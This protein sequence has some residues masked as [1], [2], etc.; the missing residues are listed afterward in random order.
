[1]L[2][3]QSS[4]HLAEINSKQMKVKVLTGK[5]F[6]VS[7]MLIAGISQVLAQV[8]GKVSDERDNPIPFANVVL[9]QAVDTTLVTGAITDDAGYFSLEPTGV[10]PFRVRVTYLG[11]AD[12][13]SEPF[14]L[15][16]GSPSLQLGTLVLTENVNELDEVVLAARRDWVQRTPE[17]QVINVQSSVMTKGS[18]ALQLLERLP[19][20]IL[21]RRDD[22]FSLNGQSGVTVLFNGR[23]VSMSMED[24]MALLESTLADNIEKVELVTSPSAKYDAD[25]GAGIINIIF[26][27]GM[28]EGSQWNYSASLGYGY[29]EKASTSLGYSFGTEK[30]H[31]NANYS[32]FHDHGKNG[33]EGSGTSFQPILG[34]PSQAIFSTYFNNNNNAHNVNLGM[35][36]QMS[37]KVELGGELTLNFSRN[38]SMSDVN[39]QRI[40]E[41]QDYFRSHLVSEGTSTKTNLISS[42]YLIDKLTDDSSLAVD[43]SYLNYT[44]DNPASTTSKYFDENDEPYNP[45]N[46]I[47]TDGNRGFSESTIQLGVLKLDYSHT[48]NDKLEGEFGFKGSYSDNTNDSKIETQV[49]GEWIVDPRSQSLIESD[50]TLWAVYS[51]FHVQLHEKSKVDLGLRYEDWRRSLST[52]EEDFTI[53]QFFPSVSY[54][55]QLSENRQLNLNY[56]RRISRPAYSDLVTSLYYNDPTA[57]FTGNPMLRPGITNTLQLEYVKNGFS[58]GL[59]LQKEIDPIIRYQLTSTPQNDI[60]VVSPQNADYQKSIGLFLN[61]PVQWASWA[62]LNVSS[63]SAIRDYKISYSP[64]PA[65]KTYFYQSLNFNQSIKLP[66]QMDVELSGWYNFDHYNGTNSTKG[67][68]V[69]NFGISKQFKNDWGTLQFSVSDVFRSL[70]IH[71]HLSGMT[72]IVF[73]IDTRSRYRDESAFTRIFRLT[74]SRSFGGNANKKS[75]NLEKEEFNRVN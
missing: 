11:F 44:N 25:G 5:N 62:R 12:Y 13:Y 72:P 14:H 45:E 6:W 54:Q 9:Y 52:S 37:P 4:L 35:G 46:E 74:Y 34:A 43:L 71:T 29:W 22:Q 73:D 56:H 67:F 19:G 58:M 66:W 75:R 68:G 50:E 60:L 49:E 38:R 48:F 61:I 65:S 18:N 51:Q 69:M 26:K 39:N 21:D 63:T 20:V 1:M 42:V 36:Y 24:V 47:F 28:N 27:K 55:Y 32:L 3:W 10:G 30:M 23:R 7:L 40:I 17:G 57:I 15:N 41:G 31:L 16:S 33:F 64:N 8:R 2:V 59:S 70:D 53:R